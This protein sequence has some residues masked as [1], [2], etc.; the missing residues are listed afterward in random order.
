MPNFVH[1]KQL[2][3]ELV[4]TEYEIHDHIK[5]PSPLASVAFNE[6]EKFIDHYLLE[7]YMDLFLYKKVNKYMGLTFDQFIDRPR[8]EI[9]KI[10]IAIDGIMAKE[11]NVGDNALSDLAK[12]NKAANK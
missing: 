7:T 12:A 1:A 2:L 5:N 6:N 4:E 11:A 8:Y 3:I 10:I 9:D